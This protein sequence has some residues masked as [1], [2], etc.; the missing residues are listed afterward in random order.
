MD[1]YDVQLRL[2]EKMLGTVPKN[3]EIYSAFIESKAEAR[4]EMPGEE[5]LPHDELS[6]VVEEMESQGWTGFHR[7]GNAGPLLIYSYMIKGFLKNAANVIKGACGEFCLKK[8]DG[9]FAN[10]KSHVNNYIFVSPRVL[11]FT[12][13]DGEPVVEADGV[14]ERPLRA[15]TAQGPR[16]ALVKSDYINAGRT[17]S[18]CITVIDGHPFKHIDTF[19]ERLLA[20]GEFQA[21]G[22]W[23]NAGYGT[24]AVESMKLRK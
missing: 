16:T 12:K 14:L 19:L 2:T 8:S 20:Y 15:Q 13:E 10:L 21:L 23:R 6:T 22:Q 4:V 17:L 11:C 18:V 3:K 7:E 1:K 5:L 9:G 24:F